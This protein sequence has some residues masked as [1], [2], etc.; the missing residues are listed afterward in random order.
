M[1]C[2]LF[3]LFSKNFTLRLLG[4]LDHVLVSCAIS[5]SV[6]M[7]NYIFFLREISPE[8][9][10]L[11]VRFSFWLNV[12]LRINSCARETVIQV[13]IEKHFSRNSA[14]ESANSQNKDFMLP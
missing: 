9:L 10:G 7:D 11:N 1:R 12:A 6:F 14:S 2:R 4:R 5:R 3:L 13:K 8:F